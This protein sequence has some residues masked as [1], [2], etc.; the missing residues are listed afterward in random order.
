MKEH[1]ITT[2]DQLI[3]G[4]GS[5]VLETFNSLLTLNID[6]DPPP[7]IALTMQFAGTVNGPGNLTTNGPLDWD[8]DFSGSG[9]LNINANAIWRGRTLSRNTTIANGVIVDLTGTTG[10]TLASATLTNN[11]TINWLDGGGIGWGGAPAI[12]NNGVFNLHVA[13]YMGSAGGTCLFT[14][15]GTVNKTTAG[16]TSLAYVNFNNPGIVNVSNG[17]LGIGRTTVTNTGNVILQDGTVSIVNY[18]ANFINSTT[19]FIKGNGSIVNGWDF[20]NNGT[21]APGVSPGIITIT[22][23]QILSA[24]STLAIEMLNGSG[25]GTGHDQLISTDNLILA[26]TLNVTEMVSVPEGVYT[27]IQ[28]TTGTISGSFQHC[29]AASM[30]YVANQQHQCDGD[31][32]ASGCDLSC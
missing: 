10:K 22:G 24:N 14:N 23:P 26:G 12:I 2:P 1:F 16:T 4:S 11:G 29:R 21:I 15:N 27:I 17:T 7:S 28:L 9:T 19:G 20:T 3:T 31:Q 5:L 18:Q 8:G 6:L 30:L 25:P 13:D 32:D